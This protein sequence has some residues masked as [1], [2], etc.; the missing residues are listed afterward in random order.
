M[1]SVIATLNNRAK[2]LNFGLWGI[3]SQHHCSGPI[4]VHIA[5]GGSCD[6]LDNYL[7]DWSYKFETVTKYTIDRNKSYYR[8]YYNC[9][10]LEYNF[11]VS[12][13]RYPFILKIDP[14]LVLITP[15]FISKSMETLQKNHKAFTMPLP[16]HT[17][18]FDFKTLYDIKIK[19][20]DFIYPTHINAS[21]AK[22]VNV[23]YACMFIKATFMELGG[24]DMRFVNHIGSEDNHFLERWRKKHGDHN[25][26]TFISENGVHLWHGR[27]GREAPH[28]ALEDIKAGAS[29]HKKLKRVDPNNGKFHTVIFPENIPKKTWMNGK[30]IQ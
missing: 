22:Q 13:A 24:I 30:V 18:K 17:Y 2:L 7:C 4:D 3:Y 19:Y 27:W 12:R 5:D 29:L 15:D 20:Q 16:F 11:L 28:Y 10:A 9:P 8:H 25:V 14:E 26:I 1:I 21:N 23:Y 6:G